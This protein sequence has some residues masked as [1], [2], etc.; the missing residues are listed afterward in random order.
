[1]QFKLIIKFLKKNEKM[2]C[3]FISKY[4]KFVNEKLFFLNLI[5]I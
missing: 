3:A 4:I 2:F 1:M 5:L